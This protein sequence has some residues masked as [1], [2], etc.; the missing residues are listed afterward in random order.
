MAVVIPQVV[1]EVSASGAQV[2]DGSLDLDGAQQQY[3]SRDPSTAGNQMTF[4]YAGWFERS[5]FGNEVILF[6]ADEDNTNVHN[7][8]VLRIEATPQMTF[9]N[10]NSNSTGVTLKTSQ[11][12]RDTGWYHVVL[13][14]DTTD[15]TSSNRVKLYIN[16]EQVKDFAT[17]TYPAQNYQ[18]QINSTNYQWV[19]REA[20][21]YYYRGKMSQVYLIDG[22]QLE[23]TEFG[24]TD[25]LTNTW[26]P[27]KFESPT[28]PN[29]GKTWSSGITGTSGGASVTV[30]TPANA[31]D[32]SVS[33]KA[34]FT[35]SAG[36][37]SIIT[38]TPPGG[39]ISGSTF[40][41][42]CY[43]PQ[44]TS[45]ANQYL[46]INGGSYV[47][48][49]GNWAGVSANNDGWSTAQTI[50]GGTLTSIA[51]KLTYGGASSQY[52]NAIEVDGEL[53]I[54]D[55]DNSNGFGHNGFYLPMDGNTP[56]GEDQSGNVNNYTPYNL[57][58]GTVSMDKATGAFPTLNTINGGTIA[59]PGVRGQVSIGVTVAPKTGGG[60][61]YYFDG[62]EAPSLEQY[63]GQ[64]I[65]F[66]QQDS[67]NNNHPLKIA[68]AAD[69]SGSTQYNNGVLIGGTP[70]IT[71]YYGVDFNGSSNRMRIPHSSEE[72]KLQSD[73]TVE[74][75]VY[76]DAFVSD[77]AVFSFWDSGSTNNRNLII[78]PNASGSN[79]WTFIY[80]SSG[81]GGWTTV[82][83]PDAWTGKWTHLAYS[84]DYSATTHRAFVDG[85]LVGT[86]SAAAIY[87]ATQ[88][89]FIIGC[90]TYTNSGF[91]NGKITNVRFSNNI[92]YTDTFQPQVE[93]FATDG[94]TVFL[95][96]LS[97]TSVTTAVTTPSTPE[98]SD[99]PS[100]WKVDNLYHPSTKI[101]I[102]NDAP[103]TLYY[104]C[105]NHSGMGGSIGVSTDL[106]IADPH[107]SKCVVALPLAG[108]SEDVSASVACTSIPKKVTDEGN[109]ASTTLSAPFYGSSY[110]FDGSGDHIAVTSP[111][112]FGTVFC[113]EAWIYHEGGGD[114]IL[115]S[116]SAS[117]SASN[118]SYIESQTA[119]ELRIKSDPGA[120]ADTP[121]K[122]YSED[123]W[124][125]VAHT[126]DGTTGKL[127]V[128]GQLSPN[129]YSANGWTPGKF[130][131]LRLAGGGGFGGDYT[132]QISDY[133]CYVGTTKY[134]GNFNPPAIKADILP[135][136]SSGVAYS[137]ELTKVIDG[138][139][140]FDA[141]GDYLSGS[142]TDTFVSDAK[143]TIDGF[144]YLNSAPSSGATAVI[145]DTG[146]GG[147]DPEL[148]VY[149]NSGNVQLYESL[150]NNTNWDAGA[151][152]M[153]VGRWYY[154]K[155]TVNGTSATDSSAIHK[156]YID[157][158]V[159]VSNTINLSSRSGAS[160]FS[161]G[162][163][164]N[165]SLLLD[166]YISNLRY[167]SVVDDSSVVPTSPLTNVINSGTAATKL[168]C[169]Q[170]SASAT[171]AAVT[172]ESLTANGDAAATN[173]NPFNTDIT[174]VLGEETDYCTM[175]PLTNAH[176]VTLS[177][178]NLKCTW[179]SDGD[180]EAV[181]GTIAIPMGVA[182]KF[183]WE[184][185]ITAGTGGGLDFGIVRSDQM[186]WMDGST[187]NRVYNDPEF[188]GLLGNSGAFRNKTGTDSDVSSYLSSISNGSSQTFM[189]CVDAFKGKMWI[190]R[191]GVWGNNG[192]RGN[193][194]LGRNPGTSNLYKDT[195]YSYLP[196]QMGASDSGT[197]TTV[198]NFGQK[199]F[200]YTPPEGFQP[201]CLANLESP[202][203]VRPDTAVGIV[204]YTGTITDT[205][206]QPISDVPFQP[207]MTWIK[208]RDGTNSSQL[209][210]SVRGAGKWL[211]S[212]GNAAEQSSN[213]NGVLTTFNLNGFNLTGGS[214]NANLCCED[215]F[216]YV[217]WNWKAG[218]N[219]NTF[220]VDDV[221]YASAAAAGLNGGTITP[222]GAS[223]GT[224]QGFSIIG[225]TGTGSAGTLSHGLSQA[226]GLII[227]KGRN[228]TDDWRVYHS[229]LDSS[230]PEDYYLILQSTNGK[231]AD[232]GA[233]F[234]ND[235]APTN[236]V[237][238]LGTDSA[239]NGSS[240]TM[241]AY[242]WHD[243][244]GLQKF[245]KYEGN[246]SASDG[247]FVY[248]GFRPALLITKKISSTSNWIMWDKE[249]SPYNVANNYL[250]ANS[251]DAQDTDGIKGVDF[252]SNGFKMYNN[253][254][255]ANNDDSDYIYMAWADSPFHNL[256]GGE[257][258]AR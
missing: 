244:P 114:Y 60:N 117:G 220:N 218:G 199:P 126:S 146:S 57:G 80:N 130:Q 203:L 9:I 207:D 150:S 19:G 147:S 196:I 31:F 212:S 208:R 119:G 41:I 176:G 179:P 204:T 213:T 92:R 197:S 54:D 83:N 69:A 169:C 53:L 214:T 115:T 184:L 246:G 164:T 26:R 108:V 70:G 165:A 94:N 91:F 98:T 39:S 198:W 28:S 188:A 4:T 122:F 195:I 245:G 239:I 16:G 96:C 52:I 173:F 76:L 29:N 254:T 148:N 255:D 187:S 78:G 21:G 87:N 181:A 227:M 132:G 64:T 49:S 230:E 216:T 88:S 190:G 93:P 40:R 248:L 257:A 86:N 71:T 75:W 103:N 116:S 205:S 159:G 25:P 102:P 12:F 200:K 180:G 85:V 223:V 13:A 68:T 177:D 172:P 97:G 228:F 145:F 48:D 67:T 111:V 152:Y 107:A 36:D 249:R 158:K 192:G 61:A 22:K 27:K 112:G 32:Y 44:G 104:Y 151:P 178:G 47:I 34:T 33:T 161:I 235:T 59:T 166:G 30:T 139:V 142:S 101:T 141:S 81:S 123:Q 231:S 5:D 129:T 17:S 11:Y 1:T 43:Q 154:F 2:I 215:G 163:R 256:Y 175:N 191:N 185:D 247:V 253:Y 77:G 15:G 46:S 143:Y 138:S 23:P 211:E 118:Y 73:F 160:V 51:L 134:T 135:N 3:L 153:K 65:T 149:N 226:P 38:F 10:N 219:N 89:P 182:G 242:C 124:F 137:S 82:A 136:T 18:T 35:H 62:V 74:G 133:R 209:V 79:K 186:S 193:P 233:S 206:I 63:R 24:Y 100:V 241:I 55:L 202:A 234:M 174:T 105:G 131:F 99:A 110:D 232:Q 171:I 183:Y 156:L 106:H 128:N 251:T 168:L 109:A 238:S 140:V 50:P 72:F 229:Y 95:G 252:L 56:V 127:Y 224:K 167:R 45:S 6:G 240:R 20:R 250:Y 113:Q 222:T 90:N 58:A 14:V 37:D 225:Y 8:C 236:T 162:A 42:Y 237:F 66:D 221:G 258:N 7:W 194:A 155:Q 121:A 157:G 144:I 125:H 217:S 120:S 170:S 210:D 243:V 189:V 201:L 84:Y